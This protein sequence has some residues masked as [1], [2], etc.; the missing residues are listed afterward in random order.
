MANLQLLSWLSAKGPGVCWGEGEAA[1]V[2]T[3][4]TL[5][6]PASMEASSPCSAPAVLARGVTLEG[7]K[8][9]LDHAELTSDF[10]LGVSK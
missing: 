5:S 10:P 7:L 9:P 4:G 8:Y 1:A 3:E 6:F 2:V